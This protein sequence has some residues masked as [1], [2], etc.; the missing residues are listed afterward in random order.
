MWLSL[1]PNANVLDGRG[2]Y[3]VHDTCKCSCA[4]VLAVAQGLRLLLELLYRLA[5]LCRILRF[6]CSPRIVEATELYRYTGAN[7]DQRRQCAFVECCSTFMLE[8]LR[9][10]I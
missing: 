4:V 7:A 9:S 1:Q 5:R 10:G 3:R 2:E 8:D 6:E